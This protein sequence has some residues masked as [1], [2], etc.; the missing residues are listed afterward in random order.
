MYCPL[1]C[2]HANL[3]LTVY[4]HGI[5][6]YR[7]LACSS[8]N[9]DIIRLLSCS[10]GKALLD[11]LNF[12][13]CAGEVTSIASKVSCFCQPAKAANELWIQGEQCAIAVGDM[14][15]KGNLCQVKNSTSLL[16]T[17]M[18]NILGLL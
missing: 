1:V 13:E 5:L 2:I 9:N 6:C 15:G 16:T 10:V 17:C 18:D 3:L 14:N 12:K 7:S 8:L 4:Q 11:V